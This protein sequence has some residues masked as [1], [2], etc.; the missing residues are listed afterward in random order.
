MPRGA[1]SEELGN[2][3][4]FRE[5]AGANAASWYRFLIGPC[6]RE[7]KNGDIRIVVGC[8]KTTS[9]GIATFP[10]ADQTQ[11]NSCHLEFGLSE[12]N[13]TYTRSEYSGVA[14]VRTGPDSDEIDELKIDGDPPDIQF[15]NQCLFVRT[16]NVTLADD[17]WTDILTSSGLIPVDSRSSEYSASDIVDSDKLE[18]SCK[19]CTYILN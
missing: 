11:Q 9:W 13:F 1:R 12:G 16:L 17:I 2:L 8:D 7:V 18:H 19:P 4:G 5:Y 3:A 6:E 10:A 15:E 14:D